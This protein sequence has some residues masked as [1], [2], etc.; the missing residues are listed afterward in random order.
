[1][2][3]NV[4]DLLDFLAKPYETIPPERRKRASATVSALSQAW[5]TLA[6]E[7]RK[8][9]LDFLKANRKK[10]LPLQ[11][12]YIDSLL[13]HITKDSAYLRGIADTLPKIAID[14]PLGIGTF[15]SLISLHFNAAPEERPA[16][17]D[18]LGRDAIQ[19]FYNRPLSLTREIYRHVVADDVKPF[20]ANG[21]VVI[22][23]KQF[24][25][26]PHAPSV[27]TLNFARTLKAEH[28]KTPVILVTQEFPNDHD[29]CVAPCPAANMDKGF[30]K[31][32][33]VSWM[34]E[35][36][37][38]AMLSDGPI[39]E[40]SVARGLATIAHLNPEMIISIGSPSLF[41]ET[42]AD[43]RF[44]FLYQTITGLPYVGDCYFHTWE[45]PDDA[46]QAEIEAR[47]LQDQY[48]FAQHP[49]F[50]EKTAQAELSRATYDIPADAFIFAVV[51]LRLDREVDDAFLEMCGAIA[52][53]NP[54]ACFAFAGNFSKFEKLLANHP[55]LTPHARYIG[56]HTDIMAVYGMCDAFLN[57][58]RK[59]GGGGIV[60]AMQAGLPAL[61]TPFGDAGLA[62]KNLPDI[63]DYEAMAATALKLM[64]DDAFR[65]DYAARSLAESKRMS[66]GSEIIARIVGEFDKYAATR[67]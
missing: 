28:G 26:P 64:E 24:L 50:D 30:L 56:F 40:V 49:G 55:A 7:S 18:H 25:R 60:Y 45:E 10:A 5:D 42:F 19:T 54:K 67:G 33:T 1:M 62:V 12:C 21:I 46:M 15:F 8:N 11:R 29:S 27:R 23:T 35:T 36:I 17:E 4:Q 61:S 58:I 59:G 53:Q 39:S 32:D 34:G 51:G 57:P 31:A 37:R 66:S 9:L 52:A 13:Y 44:C 47:G 22:L 20:E 16:L 65:E 6:P 63:A 43:S 2:D 14:I 41:A 48:L 38:F 3:D